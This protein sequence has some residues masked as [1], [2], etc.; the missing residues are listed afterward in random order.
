M[1][2]TIL[3]KLEQI[4]KENGKMGTIVGVLIILVS[5]IFVVSMFYLL[6]KF[7]VDILNFA[8]NYIIKN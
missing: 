6:T 8:I 3:N 2:V 1:L 7:Y 5:T 4:E